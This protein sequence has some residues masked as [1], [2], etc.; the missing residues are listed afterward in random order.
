MDLGADVG[1]FWE[2][3]NITS[4]GNKRRR[5]AD[6][7]SVHLHAYFVYYLAVTIVSAS[8]NVCTRFYFIL[9]FCFKVLFIFEKL[10][11]LIYYS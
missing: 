8:P 9:F 5:A 10:F 1:G 2:E 3:K 7:N 11:L 6:C 4:A